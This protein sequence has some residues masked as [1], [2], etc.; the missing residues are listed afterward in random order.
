MTLS[1]CNCLWRYLTNT[2]SS[3]Y[4][5]PGTNQNSDNR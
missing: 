5:C 4:V 3:V 2:T 1:P